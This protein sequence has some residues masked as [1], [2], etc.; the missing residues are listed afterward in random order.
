MPSSRDYAQ[1][2]LQLYEQMA[3]AGFQA[4]DI[5]MVKQAY[6]LAQKIFSAKFRGSGRPFL[7]HL[8]G[9]ASILVKYDASIKV[10]VLGLLHSAYA[11]GD[12]GTGIGGITAAKRQF[13]VAE[14]GR[15]N[16]AMIHAY[17]LYRVRPET[18]ARVVQQSASIDEMEQDML[19]THLANTLED[20]LL[21]NYIY[22]G[23]KKR[24]RCESKLPEAIAMAKATQNPE[25]AD[26]LSR[27]LQQHKE[28]TA[29]Q[30]DNASYTVVPQSYRLGL[31]PFLVK[32][33]RFLQQLVSRKTSNILHL[34]FG[35]KKNV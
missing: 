21:D 24:K 20:A 3:A 11:F 13:L 7:A 10:I 2:N 4:E 9:T 34:F 27:C 26:E 6:G 18:Y 8:V 16:E 22:S 23:P 17:A 25:L 29:H 15:D 12:F 35:R 33:K 28:V 14:L 30:G 5:Q 32:L 1:T 31:Y 19:I